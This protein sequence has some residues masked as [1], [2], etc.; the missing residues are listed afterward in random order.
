MSDLGIYLVAV[1]AIWVLMAWCF[2]LLADG[3]RHATKAQ[4]ARRL[5]ATGRETAAAM[6]DGSVARRKPPR[7][8]APSPEASGDPDPIAVGVRNRR[9]R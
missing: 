3:R 9:V 7:D 8:V 6:A 4:T 5:A 2:G 1:L